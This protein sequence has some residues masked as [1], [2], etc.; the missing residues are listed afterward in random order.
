[1]PSVSPVAVRASRSVRVEGPGTVLGWGQWPSPSS[2]PVGAH[3]PSQ[4]RVA[5][6]RERE[7][8][9]LDARR[10]LKS[11]CCFRESI[12]ESSLQCFTGI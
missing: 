10:D 8:I 7:H 1:M 12:S 11:K 4:A 5:G 3:V 9:V 6:K 2:G